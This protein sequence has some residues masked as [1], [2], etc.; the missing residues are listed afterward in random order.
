M[1]CRIHALHRNSERR[2]YKCVQT[3][4]VPVLEQCLYFRFHTLFQGVS[5]KKKKKNLKYSF[6]YFHHFHEILC[7][8]PWCFIKK[9]PPQ[10]KWCEIWNAKKMLCE[11]MPGY[12]FTYFSL[13]HISHS[14]HGISWKVRSCLHTTFKIISCNS[15]DKIHSILKKFSRDFRKNFIKF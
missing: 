6:T 15:E 4:W 11:N 1:N 14:L 9:P 8:K 10:T 12:N 13:F 7:N 2:C 5:R 3:E